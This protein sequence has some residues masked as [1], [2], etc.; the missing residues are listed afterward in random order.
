MLLDHRYEFGLFAFRSEEE[1]FWRRGTLPPC[2][3]FCLALDPPV[4]KY[5]Q[6]IFMHVRAMSTSSLP[7]FVNIH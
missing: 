1:A 2:D 7:S 6:N 3:L 5:G 4:G